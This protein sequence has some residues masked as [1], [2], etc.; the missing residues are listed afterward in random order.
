M[1]LHVGKQQTRFDYA[2]ERYWKIQHPSLPP[3]TRFSGILLSDVWTHLVPN[4]QKC[5]NNNTISTYGELFLNNLETYETLSF[6]EPVLCHRRL[7][8]IKWTFLCY[9]LLVL[10][11][12]LNDSSSFSLHL[13]KMSLKCVKIDILL[14]GM[15][16]CNVLLICIK[17]PIKP[18]QSCHYHV[19]K[20]YDFNLT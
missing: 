3:S 20:V 4:D 9:R 19:L 2:H 13:M 10:S 1:N 8:S 11:I 18:F 15:L 5:E 14:V 17:P 16:L 6:N 7:V 12:K